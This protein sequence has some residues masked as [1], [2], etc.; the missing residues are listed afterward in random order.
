MRFA[1]ARYK[2]LAASEEDA[3]VA[4]E[5]DS[6]ETSPA[7]TWRRARGSIWLRT[8]VVAIVAWTLGLAAG[9]QWTAPSRTSTFTAGLLSR[10]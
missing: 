6:R 8:A 10:R 3:E 2:E 4:S 1:D 5:Q 9:R 7:S